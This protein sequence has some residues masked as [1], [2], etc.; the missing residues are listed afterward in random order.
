MRPIVIAGGCYIETCEAPR[1][2]AVYGSGGRAAHALVGQVPVRLHS[3]YP[4]SRE[5]ELYP[6]V[7]AGV[8]LKTIYSPS[9]IAFAYFHP[10]SDPSM[11]PDRSSI[12]QSAPLRVEGDAVL[13]FGMVEGDAVVAGRRVVYDP[14]SINDFAPFAQNGSSAESLALVLNADELRAATGHD[15]LEVA[16]IALLD[17]GAEVVIAKDGVRGALVYARDIPGTIVP[18]FWSESVFKIGTGDVFSAAFTYA[19]A[20]LEK[21]ALAAAHAAS[22]S[23]AHYAD[24]LTLPLLSTEAL[25]EGIPVHASRRGHVNLLGSPSRLAD[26]WL[27]EEV[28]WRLEQLGSSVFRLDATSPSH[29]LEGATLVLADQFGADALKLL[30]RI[31]DPDRMVILTETGIA[32]PPGAHITADF[33]TAMYWSCWLA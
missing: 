20:Y 17:G 19:W 31:L 4:K 1:W 7:A 18:A 27:L 11:A 24:K 5:A 8:E 29:Q 16:A 15:D 23:V 3:Y 30:T 26:R 25:P 10:L 6:L 32:G 2:R 21:P 12:V 22:R 14:Q 28:A 13:R 9:A 33:S